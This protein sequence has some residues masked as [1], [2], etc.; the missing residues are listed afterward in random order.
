MT[1]RMWI[2]AEDRYIHEDNER[3]LHEHQ[4]KIRK[5]VS[6]LKRK[7]DY[8]EGGLKKFRSYLDPKANRWVIEVE[9]DDPTYQFPRVEG[10]RV[11]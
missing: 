4:E 6:E 9:T 7:A 5:V 8:G 3:E 1:K 10:M 2:E 11:S